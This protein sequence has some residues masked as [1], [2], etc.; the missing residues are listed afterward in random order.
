MENRPTLTG[1]ICAVGKVDQQK[2]LKQKGCIMWI[3]GLSCS[4]LLLH[5]QHM[6]RSYQECSSFYLSFHSTSSNLDD[7]NRVVYVQT[8]W[9]DS[10]TERQWHYGAHHIGIRVASYAGLRNSKIIS[11]INM[12]AEKIGDLCW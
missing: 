8:Q 5:C 3:T 9:M 2:L 11:L 4:G 12:D 7:R 1:R 6:D 10:F